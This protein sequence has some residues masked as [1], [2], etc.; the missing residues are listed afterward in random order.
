[1]KDRK[2]FLVRSE[3]KAA[4]MRPHFSDEWVIK[5]IGS[6]LTGYRFSVILV[7]DQDDRFKTPAEWGK[8]MGQLRTKLA[9]GGKLIEVY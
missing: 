1:M 3:A 8:F 6:A 9:P 2:L 5:G 4:D 7:A